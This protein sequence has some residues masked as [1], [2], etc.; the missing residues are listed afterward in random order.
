M[1]I[2][3]KQKR[4][5]AFTLALL[6]LISTL[7]LP[8][9]APAS[10]TVL[11]F[12]GEVV[13]ENMYKYWMCTYKSVFANTYSD[14]SNTS[15]FWNSVMENGQTA[16]E[17]LSATVLE[18]VKLTLICAAKFDS[19]RG[20]LTQK[21]L[22][23]IDERIEDYK[24]EYA[25]GSTKIFNSILAE[26]G[27]NVKILRE[28]YIMEAKAVALLDLLY[29]D[30]GI[31]TVSPDEKDAYYED[32]YARI[33]MIYIND[34]FEYVTDEN[35][36]YYTDE[37]GYYVTE[38]LD[39][40]SLAKKKADIAAVESALEDGT[41][42]SMLYKKYSEDTS[43]ENGYYMSASMTF[44]KEVVDAAMDLK[45]NE[46]CTV[47]SEY[48]THIIKRVALEEKGYEKE[49]NKSFFT[50]FDSDLKDDL[51]IKYAEQF[52]NQVTADEDIISQYK[53]SKLPANS[54]H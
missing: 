4:G 8:S 37:N 40:K 33:L 13:T 44:I 6:L 46:W 43:Y 17:Y 19:L 38:E 32:N 41:D 53:L 36:K 3:R 20:K 51:F 23:A 47:E 10:K 11:E 24:T 18:N 22:D 14:F 49:E 21:Q 45:T 30:S 9:C 2:F 31:L 16:E 42:F 5:V 27:V 52:L 35:G 12:D 15:A 29:G 7:T 1:S 48:G 28:I 26:Y 39:E 50:S 34:K 54:I 25:D